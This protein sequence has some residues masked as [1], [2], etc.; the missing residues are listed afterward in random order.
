MAK[1]LKILIASSHD[2]SQHLLNF[3]MCVLHIYFRTWLVNWSY[4][5]EKT[6]ARACARSL[7]IAD[8]LRR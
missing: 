4:S 3:V 2:I 5:T 6:Y 8:A 7:Q 1:L